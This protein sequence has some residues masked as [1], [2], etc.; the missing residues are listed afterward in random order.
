MSLC[1]LRWTCKHRLPDEVVMG[2]RKEHTVFGRI[3]Q[4][5]DNKAEQVWDMFSDELLAGIAGRWH[6]PQQGQIWGH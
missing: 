4:F 6:L 5:K 3:E 2:E 1:S